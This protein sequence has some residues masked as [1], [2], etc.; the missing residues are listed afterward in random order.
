MHK[1]WD[2][3]WGWLIDQIGGH[4]CFAL[5]SLW[6]WVLA[7]VSVG[8]EEEHT[9]AIWLGIGWAVF[10]LLLFSVAHRSNKPSK[11]E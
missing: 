9:I 3:L 8:H 6:T 11:E 2:S 7:L 1:M 4:G 5:L 10:M